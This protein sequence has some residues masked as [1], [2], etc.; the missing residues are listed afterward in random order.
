[1]ISLN[2]GRSVGQLS[3]VKALHRQDLQTERKG[4][5]HYLS[6]HCLTR[7]IYETRTLVSAA[8]VEDAGSPIFAFGSAD[9]QG[10]RDG[11]TAQLE[12]TFRL[13]QSQ[14]LSAIP[15]QVCLRPLSHQGNPT[16]RKLT[17]ACMTNSTLKCKLIGF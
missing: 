17:A 14:Q 4:V 8:S 2:S 15:M 3:N 9:R 11:M 16:E 7:R 1:M 5:K 10:T 6:C 12:F 13:M